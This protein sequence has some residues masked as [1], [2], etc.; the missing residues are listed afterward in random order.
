MDITCTH[1]NTICEVTPKTQG[2][3]ECLQ[4][5][6]KWVHLRMCL[7][8][9]HVGCC[10]ESP[11]KHATAHFHEEAHPLM[12]SIEPGESWVWC[13]VD[14]I[15]MYPLGDGLEG[16]GAAASEEFLRQIP[17]F[18]ELEHDDLDRIYS[19]AKP[20]VVAEGET[21]VR[22]GD[23]GDS[24]YVVL[25]GEFE[26]TKRS[27]GSELLLSRRKPG[28]I[29][30]EMS[31]LAAEP[32]AATVR[33][34]QESRV[35]AISRY[36]FE[37]LLACSPSAGMTLLKTMAH[38]LRSNETLLTQQE[39]MA[40]LGRLTAGLAHELNNPAAAAWRST[41][42]LTRTLTE[43][44]NLSSQL[45]ALSLD[46]EAMSHIS[47]L[48]EELGKRA[49]QKVEL[50]PLARG[51]QESD[52]QFW[53]ED[54]SVEGAWELAP[55]LV[56]LGWDTSQL[57]EWLGG[58]EETHLAII[59]PWLVKGAQCYILVD[60]VRI[61]AERISEIVKAV[62]SYSYLDQ[63]PVQQVDLQEGLENT[64]VILKHKLKGGI[65]V[66]REYAPD[67]PRVEA[68]ASELN[69]VWTNLI[70]NAID[71]MDGKG[72]LTLR[73]YR[74]GPG[75]VA[76]EIEDSGPGIPPD[77]QPRIFQP[78]FTTKE[79]GK[80]TGLGLHIVYNIVVDKHHGQVSFTSEPGKT[81]FTVTL[82]VELVRE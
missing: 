3:E 11:N 81:C 19:L 32:R 61:S 68:Y 56:A 47:A 30:G 48:R 65:E 46:P 2:C 51:D 57:E 74:D 36:A 21:L 6:D 33:A 70:D 53:L 40:G 58:F 8:C 82:P 5:G 24:L 45:D 59:V 41:D 52:L 64:L 10:D 12:R 28:E 63:A 55:V 25:S 18:A 69:Q 77:T 49:S 22:E 37:Q 71:A 29:V 79:I 80:G 50:D 75:S 23:E 35:L 1:L 67:L 42:Q 16:Y 39:K 34:L 4:K 26:V 15:V 54:R 43:W 72:A 78:F 44:Q 9:G 13:Y 38:R 27:M 14:H 20:V 17:I 66:K 62:K 31:L 7:G 60:E 73:A 76:V